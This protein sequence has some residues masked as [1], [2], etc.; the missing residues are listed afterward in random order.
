MKLTSAIPLAVAALLLACGDDDSDSPAQLKLRVAH[1]SPD[2]P[3]V[4]VCL[5]PAGTG[6]FTGPVLEQAGGAAGLAY[7]QATRYLD[8]DARTYDVRIVGA[9]APNCDTAIVPDTTGVALE[10]GRALTVAAIGLAAPGA[11]QPGFEL[12]PLVDDTVVA[13]GSAKVRFVHAAPG[14]PPVD[15]GAGTGA[16]FTPLFSAVS[17]GSV[18]AD[19]GSTGYLETAPL[20]GATLSARA[21]G[22]DDDALVVENVTL[23][24]GTIVTV[25]AAGVL[26]GSPPLTALVC[27]DQVAETALLS[28]CGFAP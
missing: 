25:F 2:A 20:V 3:P 12:L 19:R 28:D 5:A 23:P 24:A 16:A 6:R 14:A 4:D 18:D 9:T 21:T 22:T 27:A 8:V 17:F 26:G 13:P 15:V 11:G 10:A 7:G 1:L